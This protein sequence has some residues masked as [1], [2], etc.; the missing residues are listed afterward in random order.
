MA[1]INCKECGNKVSDKASTCPKCGAPIGKITVKTTK[2]QEIDQKIQDTFPAKNKK[3]G[4]WQIITILVIVCLGFFVYFFVQ[5][6]S[7]IIPGVKIEINTPNP[8]VISSRADEINSTLIKRKVTVY[9]TIQNHGGDGNVLVTF[10][11]S[12]AGNDYQRSQP[13]AMKSGEIVDL[14]ETFTEVKM[15]EGQVTFNVETRAD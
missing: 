2:T 13:I 5:N 1:L 14:N 8:S 3:N 7:G 11:V 6:N 9:A 4:S 15:L 10:S 12:Q